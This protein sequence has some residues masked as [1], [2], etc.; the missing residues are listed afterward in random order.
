VRELTL[1]V[2]A[3]D[4]D[5]VLDAVLPALPG[6]AHLREEGDEAAVAV[7]ARVGTPDEEELR[8]LAGERLKGLT[9]AEVPDDWRERRLARYEPLVVAERFLV[10]PDWAPAAEG[11]DLLEVALLESGAFGTGVH[12]TTRGCLA[13]MAGLTPEGSFGDYG[14]GSGVLSIAAARLGFSPVL[15]VDVNEP[16]LDATRA[17]ASRNGV[18]ID[19]RQV[20]LTA[21]PPPRA[22]TVAVN[23]PPDIQ[24][25][26]T[27][28]LDAVP[29]LVIASGFTTA[30][31][32]AV[33][34]AWGAHGLEVTGEERVNEWSVLVLR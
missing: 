5:E 34:A 16:S 22:E 20:D 6:G 29:S 10:R 23:V 12:P 3:T 8:R 17:N 19:A 7:L 21:E 18:E 25:A 9:V 30:D 33:A 11:G 26:L 4:L 24:L 13:A 1:R 14:C 32:E 2:A 31:V 15:A 28:N 27:A